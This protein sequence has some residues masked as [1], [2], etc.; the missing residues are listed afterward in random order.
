MILV[1]SP[2]FGSKRLA[3]QWLRE[4]VLGAAATVPVFAAVAILHRLS[5]LC[6]DKQMSCISGEVQVSDLMRSP[7][8]PLQAAISIFL[9]AL[10]NTRVSYV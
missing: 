4:H 10:G 2:V 9:V 8:L 3:A 6:A 1:A 5:C 7:F